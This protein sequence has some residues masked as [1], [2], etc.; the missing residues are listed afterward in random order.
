MIRARL[1]ALPADS[2]LA[3]ALGSRGWTEVH[4][5][6]ADLWEIQASSAKKRVTHPHRP[7]PPAGSRG[8]A[9]TA[10]TPADR[11][12]RAEAVARGR[13]RIAASRAAREA[14][15]AASGD[16]GTHTT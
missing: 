14:R 10:G 7:K 16:G 4:A 8:P 6:L 2:A 3:R 13:A 15:A 1:R 5:L 11:R 9:R 12:R